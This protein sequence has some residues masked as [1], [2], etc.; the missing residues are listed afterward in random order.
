[1][2]LIELR[3]KNNNKFKD[4]KNLLNDYGIKSL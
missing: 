4:L 3:S 1:M 2:S